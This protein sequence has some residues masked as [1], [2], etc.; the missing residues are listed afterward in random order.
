MTYATY[1]GIPVDSRPLGEALPWERTY[2]S[3]PPR[4]APPERLASLTR[5]FAAPA[6]T[7]KAHVRLRPGRPPGPPSAMFIPF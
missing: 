7:A 3:A 2:P 6:G 5:A 4:S 1:D